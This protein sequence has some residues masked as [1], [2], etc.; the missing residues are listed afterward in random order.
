MALRFYAPLTDFMWAGKTIE[1]AEGFV[2]GDDVVLPDLGETAKQLSEMEWKSVR[3]TRHW[4]TFEIQEGSPGPY[5]LANLILLALWIANPT[6]TRFEHS[7]SASD[8]GNRQSTGRNMRRFS[9]IEGKQFQDF[10]DQLLARASQLFRELL[11]LYKR[12][13]RLNPSILITL[14]G[15]WSNVW[16]N[17]LICF[18]AAAEGLLTYDTGPRITH[19]LS[20]TFACL[21]KT[22]VQE[23]EAAY[24]HFY[25]LYN[26][27]SDIMHGRTHDILEQDRLTKLEQW[28]DVIRLL[29]ATVCDRP[30]LRVALEGTDDDRRNFFLP[31]QA[32]FVAPPPP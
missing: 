2:I 28:Q 14:T 24:R 26:A 22:N 17:A 18:A 15:C 27:R 12:D 4:L 7:F 32:G 23:R 31:M 1:L 16:T 20:T 9:Y 3:E 5:A 8:D 6:R 25:S 13:T 21:T 29:W 30:D 11:E 10:S 19:R